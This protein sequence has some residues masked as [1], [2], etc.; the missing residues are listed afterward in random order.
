MP[1]E[2]VSREADAAPPR[3]PTAGD[4]PKDS[5]IEWRLRHAR[6]SILNE[7]VDQVMVADAS[8]VPGVPANGG[9]VDRSRSASS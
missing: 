2:P 6:R 9:Y 5:E 4:K 8:S 7:A 1:V 3:P